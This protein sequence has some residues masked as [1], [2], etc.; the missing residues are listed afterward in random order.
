MIYKKLEQHTSMPASIQ[1]RDSPVGIVPIGKQLFTQL[2]KGGKMKRTLLVL[3]LSCLFLVPGVLYAQ[4][5]DEPSLVNPGFSPEFWD[6]LMSGKGGEPSLQHLLDSLGYDIDVVTDL[7][8]TE[9]WVT[10]AGQ[11][12]EV[13]IAELAGYASQT[14]SGWYGHG[15]P[16]DT[17]VI[18][19]GANQPGDS[20]SFT[21]TGCDSNGLFIKVPG[22]GEKSLPYVYY[23]EKRLNSD[24]K[25]HAKVYCSKKRPNEFIVAWEDSWNLGDADY[26]DL[27]LVYR[28][29]N[30]P[31]V[32]DLPENTSFLICETETVCFDIGAYDDCGDT[33]S[34]AKLEGPGV[35]DQNAGTCCFLPA[36]VDSAY[37]F[38]FVATDQFGAADTDTVV[39][40]V[41]LNQPPQLTCPQDGQVNAG[42]VFTST[43]FSLSD[44]NGTSGVTVVLDTILPT[45]KSYP[46]LMGDKVKWQ[47]RC[48]D[49]VTGPDFTITLI[50]TDPCGVADTCQFTVTVYNLPPEIV[51]PDDDSVSAGDRFVSSNFSASDPK[52][53]PVVNLCGI[54]PTPTHM[55]IKV[56]RHVEWQTDCADA[57]KVFTICLETTDKCGAKDTCHFEVTVYNR[58]PQITCPDDD[59]VN[60]G[61]FFESSN[62]STSDPKCDPVVNLCGITPTPTHMPTKVYRHVE[63]Q[64]DCADAGK[65]FTICLEVTDK[66]G[67]KDTCYFEVTVYNRPPQITCPDD[68]S[69]YAGDRFVSSN[70]SASDPKCGPVVNLCGITPTPTHMPTKVQNHVEWQTDCADVGKVFTICLETTDKCGA[71]D[72]CYFQV[73]VYDQPP[74]ITCPDDDTVDSGHYL[75]GNFTVNDADGD[76]ISLVD[77]WVNPTGNGIT[78]VT[79]NGGTGAV[80]TTGHVEFDADSLF[81]GDYT[82]YLEATSGCETKDTCSF[83]ITIPGRPPVI[84]STPDTT[85]FVGQLYTYDVD[86]TGIAAPIFHLFRYPTGMTIDTIT[87]L[88]QWTLTAVGDSNVCVEAVNSAG[89]DTQ[90]FTISV[91]E[92]AQVSILPEVLPIQCDHEDTLWIHLDEKVVDMDSA[93]FKIAYEDTLITPDT[94]IKGPALVPPGNFDLSQVIY[95]DSIL[96]SLA[97]LSGSFDGPDTILGIVFTASN[98]VTTA[99]V[100]IER[101]SLRNSEGEE[102]PHRTSG[103]EIQIDC[104]T[105]VDGEDQGTS[106]NPSTYGLSQNYPNPYNPTTQIAYQL[107]QPGVVSLKIYNIKGELVRTLVNEYKPAGNHIAIWDGKDDAGIQLASGIYLYRIQADKFTDSKKMILIK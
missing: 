105:S 91:A 29:P 76:S 58:P 24:H 16:A 92:S 72:T 23:T 14:I 79:V 48:E 3:F 17:H 73:T 47:S 36:S 80:P 41:E 33:V 103:A 65:V 67:A 38:V 34:I 63:W 97:V 15:S 40:T 22:T 27:V 1:A 102:I 18:F 94:V 90:C 21:I 8:P 88:I 59:S 66:C 52:G 78:K 99:Q 62:F 43:S 104:P 60:A 39:I 9:V 64:T 42:D 44:P 107:P 100:S 46:F 93:F 101:S 37:E 35:F 95:P 75:S 57:G 98:Y 53:D 83:L 81:P 86:A 70:F 45:P 85:A 13:M 55:P 6:S 106:Q 84:T 32:L 11:Y 2:F 7:L 26:N 89:V 54:T 19:S 10:I 4:A 25:D 71:K 30:R 31:P 12:K 49:L 61:D 20:L 56:S 69:V 50:A 96:I 77:A 51:C 68:D 5:K 28:T 74:Q 82:I 87:G